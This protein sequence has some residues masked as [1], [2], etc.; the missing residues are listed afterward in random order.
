M[1]D[2]NNLFTDSSTFLII[3]T[4]TLTV[5]PPRHAN[6]Q[7]LRF[8]C[9]PLHIRGVKRK[10]LFAVKVFGV[11][12]FV[13]VIVNIVF[14][15]RHIS[16]IRSLDT[17]GSNEERFLRHT[18]KYH[19]GKLAFLTLLYFFTGRS[20]LK[21]EEGAPYYSLA[22]TAVVLIILSLD[23]SVLPIESSVYF[24]LKGLIL[25]IIS[26]WLVHVRK[27]VFSGKVVFEIEKK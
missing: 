15:I 17:Q 4:N 22:A 16:E 20:I 21:R 12:F 14:I 8:L 2:G 6:T 3:L 27:E 7:P 10:P 26:I 11:V 25:V 24:L 5:T 19:V 9:P 23:R 18:L 1:G 13:L